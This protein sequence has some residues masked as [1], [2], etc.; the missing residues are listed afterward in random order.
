MTFP[1]AEGHTPKRCS[2]DNGKKGA[3]LQQAVGPGEVSIVKHLREDPVFGRTRKGGLK[4][5]QEKNPQHEL[6]ASGQECKEAKAHGNDL[7]ALCHNQD[8]ALIEDIRQVACIT[9]KKEKGE[10]KKGPC[11]REVKTPPFTV[12][13]CGLNSKER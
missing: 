2:H 11:Q 3:H 1:Y 5:H 7:K 6:N 10:D 13:F 12:F 8:A 4:G 9:G